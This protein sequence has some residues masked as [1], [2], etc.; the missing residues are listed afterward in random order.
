MPPNPDLATAK[1]AHAASPAKT[2]AALAQTLAALG[3]KAG[4]N[5]IA[6]P[7]I[8]T[9]SARFTNQSVLGEGGMGKVHVALD[10]QFGREVA[11]KE[12]GDGAASEEGARR[13]VIEA[14]VTANLEHP[15]IPAVYERGM[16]DGRPFYA[17]RKIEGRPL[18][19]AMQ[20]LRTLPERLAML[21]VLAQVA[22]TLGFAHARGVVHRDVK[23]DNVLLAAH[24]A[25]VVVD[26]GIAKVKGV[27]DGGSA[28]SGQ[29]NEVVQGTL[30]GSVLG[31]PAYM[32]PEQARGDVEAI[33]A[34][35]DVFALGAMLYQLLSGRAPFQGDTS[36]AMLAAA[37]TGE[38]PAIR[39][40][41][42]DAPEGLHV[43]V[44]KAMARAP[45]DRYPNADAFAQAIG[46]FMIEA[47]TK[48]PSFAARAIIGVA[49]GVALVAL[50]IAT[51]ATIATMPGFEMQGPASY[52]YTLVALAGF[53]LTGVEWRTRGR[54]PRPGHT[55]AKMR[56]G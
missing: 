46:A 30:H 37:L 22:N 42:K 2:A 35:T 51:V 43:I 31:T 48:K 4:E 14:L 45:E 1:T 26:W 19:E 21:P 9:G 47:V 41:A 8:P 10:H 17:M 36:M 16:R 39:D 52:L 7:T 33:D 11:L 53:T 56:R 40:V 23:P 44:D 15:G 27:A 38:R 50:A 24:G 34:R 55:P 25:V 3:P 13:F 28:I 29:A 6:A 5:P 18:S 12:L 54:S 32:A 20:G 49:T